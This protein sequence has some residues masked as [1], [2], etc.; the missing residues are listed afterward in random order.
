[1]TT[2]TT[3][4]EPEVRD[5]RELE[6]NPT[7]PATPQQAAIAV[8]LLHTLPY[9]LISLYFLCLYGTQTAS[10]IFS[11]TQSLTGSITSTLVLITIIGTVFWSLFTLLSFWMD[12]VTGWLNL[13]HRAIAFLL[14]LPSLVFG[15]FYLCA[16]IGLIALKRRFRNLLLASVPGVA[17]GYICLYGV[18]T[19]LSGELAVS[20]A[21]AFLVPAATLAT[22]VSIYALIAVTAD[23][24][25]TFNRRVWTVM[26]A[27]HVVWLAVSAVLWYATAK[28]EENFAAQ[29]QQL[30]Q[31]F[32]RPLSN[33]ALAEDYYHQGQEPVA[34]SL[35]AKA[36]AAGPRHAGDGRQP[37]PFDQVQ[38]LLLDQASY[39][40]K[41]FEMLMEWTQKNAEIHA[42]MDAVT[43]GP[44]FKDAGSDKGR[45]YQA[46]AAIA[47]NLTVWAQIYHTRLHAMAAGPIENFSLDKAMELIR[48]LTWL[49]DSAL[50]DTFLLANGNCVQLEIIRL[51]ALQ[52]LL[53]MGQL[54]AAQLAELRQELERDAAAWEQRARRAYWAALA[55]YV[56]NVQD[57]DGDSLNLIPVQQQNSAFN[58]LIFGY[59]SP[60]TLWLRRADGRWAFDYAV[61]HLE[62]SLLELRSLEDEKKLAES[63]PATATISAHLLLP[64]SSQFI[65]LCALQQ[66]LRIAMACEQYR[67]TKGKLPDTTAQ[68]VPEF[69]DKLPL[70]PYSGKDF[71]YRRD[72]YKTTHDLPE[73]PGHQVTTEFPRFLVY[74]VGL[75][76][77]D[78]QGKS[79]VLVT[80][81]NGEKEARQDLAV[82]IWNWMQVRAELQKKPEPKAEQTQAKRNQQLP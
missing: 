69:M 66:A 19:M 78:N 45:R 38:Q 39:S 50:D 22:A 48:H 68:L 2:E 26:A 70:D 10:G 16:M 35:L 23:G 44:L 3:T 13:R 51:E 74:S 58:G 27:S 47:S 54:N 56:G 11:F 40:S 18:L 75:D 65:P 7:T 15:S 59:V 34:D 4:P 5:I 17:T 9:S 80:Q 30:E 46:R 41:A 14:L 29:R 37:E 81:K 49:R 60:L 64:A 8:T 62:K 20:W 67:L 33:K 55:W 72:A 52:T 25:R 53:G 43:Q 6:P 28:T 21:N 77:E 24:L 31:H 73:R 76:R 42:Q 1:M 61:S 82:C 36:V 71:L 57:L 12:K 32:G 79:Y 63:L